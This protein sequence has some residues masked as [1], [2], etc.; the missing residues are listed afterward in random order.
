V[1]IALVRLPAYEL[2]L[3]VYSGRIDAGDGASFYSE[4]DPGDPANS[5]RWLTYIDE[6]A[7]FS[8]IPVTAF[9]EAKHA[10]IPKLKQMAQ[11]PGFCSAVVCTTAHSETITSF[12]RAYVDQDPDYVSHP[13]FFTNLKDACAWLKLPDKGC[14]AVAE[15]IRIQHAAPT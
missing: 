12:W 9:P 3:I 14:E 4:L 2:T 6:N 7:D 1:G 13:A 8:A 15:A 10:L 5:R 11:R